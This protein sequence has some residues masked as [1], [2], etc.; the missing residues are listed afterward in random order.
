MQVGRA[1]SRIAEAQVHHSRLELGVI[2]LAI[3][4]I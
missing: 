4:R 1:D 3:A 2:Q